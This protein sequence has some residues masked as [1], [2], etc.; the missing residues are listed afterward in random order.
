IREVVE[1]IALIPDQI[2]AAVFIRECSQLLE[3]EERILLAEL[4]S[5]KIGQSRKASQQQQQTLR[6]QQSPEAEGPPA[7]LFADESVD[8]PFKSNAMAGSE[9]QEQEIIRLLLNYG[10]MPA[11]WEQEGNLP[12]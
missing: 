9:R 8:K 6:Q 7:D 2:K 12:I 4:N 3:I 1:S 5:M 11:K 10:H